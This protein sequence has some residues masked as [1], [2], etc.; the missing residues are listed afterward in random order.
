MPQAISSTGLGARDHR[1][2]LSMASAIGIDWGQHLAPP[3]AGPR[4]RLHCA[5]LDYLSCE[6]RLAASVHREGPP[7]FSE[8]LNGTICTWLLITNR[9]ILDTCGLAALDG[10]HGLYLRVLTYHVTS[11]TGNEYA[12]LAEAHCLDEDHELLENRAGSKLATVVQLD[13]VIENGEEDIAPYLSWEAITALICFEA[14]E[15]FGMDGRKVSDKNRHERMSD[16]PNP[17]KHLGLMG[18]PGLSWCLDDER[19]TLVPSFRF[20]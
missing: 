5:L 7:F 12:I 14:N 4:H 6:A 1:S 13:W 16:R 2:H 18:W 19:G 11:P 9:Q 3:A 17:L 10:I 20:G 8:D 15:A